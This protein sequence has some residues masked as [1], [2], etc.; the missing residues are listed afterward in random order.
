MCWAVVKGVR[1]KC[2]T[3]E[4]Y[5]LCQKCLPLAESKHPSGHTFKAIE[6]PGENATTA[7]QASSSSSGKEEHSASCDMCKKSIWGVRHKC[8]ECPD[9]DLCEKCL[10]KAEQKHSGH[11]FAHIAFPGQSKIYI[12]KTAHPS[13]VCDGCSKPIRGIR[14]KCGNCDDFDLCSNCEASP[15]PIH[16]TEHIFLKIRKPIC[17]RKAPAKPLLPMMYK[18]AWGRNMCYHPQEEGEEPCSLRTTSASTAS[19][20]SNVSNVSSVSHASNVSNTSYA[21]MA[22]SIK[23]PLEPAV[24]KPLTVP[25]SRSSVRSFSESAQPQVAQITLTPPPETQAPAKLVPAVPV[26]ESVLI[27]DSLSLPPVSM[28][29][30]PS[31]PASV[32]VSVPSPSPSPAPSAVPTV[33]P[34]SSSASTI[35]SRSVAAGSTC[36]AMLV[37]DINIHDGTVIQAGSQFLKI[38]EMLNEGPS[39]W[40]QDTVV[41]FV[42]GDRMFS[43]EQMEDQF[44]NFKI[45]LAVVGKSVCVKADLKAPALPGRYISY[46][47]LVAPTGEPFGQRVWC[48]ILVEDGTDSCSD[49]LGSSSLMI[50]PTVDAESSHANSHVGEEESRDGLGEINV[51]NSNNTVDSAHNASFMMGGSRMMSSTTS[52]HLGPSFARSMAPSIASAYT[53]DDQLSVTSELY[54]ESIYGHDESIADD[55]DDDDDSVD[56]DSDDASFWDGAEDR[57][58]YVVL[59]NESDA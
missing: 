7:T 11:G 1:H 34:Q 38:W 50:F 45:P 57:D 32:P 39:E 25:S 16:N 14:Y 17:S 44:P 26:K 28:M 56:S 51:N 53:A 55:S 43:D 47:R 23:V 52:R 49:S 36:T 2:V 30:A 19:T 40:P 35:L 31:A 54:R 13:V 33:V 18:K 6:K 22:E 8:F 48:D 4:N 24:E 46:W 5:D 21:S 10:P 15:N 9:Y 27:S 12:D 3:C 58:E 37:K 42:G 20:A 41:Q 29:F 59:D